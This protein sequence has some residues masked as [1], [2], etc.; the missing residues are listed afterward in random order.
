MTETAVRVFKRFIDVESTDA[1]S[2]TL[3]LSFSSETPVQR[4]FGTEILSHEET[5]VDLT[6]FNDSAP[7]L[8]SHNP[9]QIIGVVNRAW[10]ENKSFELLIK[11]KLLRGKSISYIYDFKIFLKKIIYG[12]KQVFSTENKK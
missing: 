4:N 2:D 9:N 8:W 5:A 7:V 3:T 10:L 1:K 6:R 11:I 12:I